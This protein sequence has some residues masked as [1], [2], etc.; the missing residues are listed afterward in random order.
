MDILVIGGTGFIS[1]HLVKKL[2]H[3]NHS[4]TILTRGISQCSLFDSSRMKVIIG[5]RNQESSLRKAIEKTTFDVVFDMVAYEREQSAAAVKVFQGKVGRFIHC[6]TVSVYMVSNEVQCPIT[7]DQDKTPLMEYFARN[8]FGMD[9]GIKKRQCEEILWAA[10]DEKTFPVTM[11]RPTYVSGPGDPARRDYFWIERILDGEPL[12]I[13]GSGD[14]AFQNVYIE[15]VAKAFVSLLDVPRSIGNAYNVAAE[16]IFSLTDYLHALC[17]L[18]NRSPE[19]V[20]VDQNIFDQQSF[21]TSP[22]GDVFTFNSRRTAI[23]SLEKIKRD[24]GYQSTPFKQWMPLTIEWV[25]NKGRQ[26]SAGYERRAEETDFALRWKKL[27]QR[28]RK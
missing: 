2:L 7:E 3:A 5:D 16:E 13:P 28:E 25:V 20:Y 8:P 24:I 4:V 10:H 15:D 27:L 23:F 26:H 18:M 14:H 9:Y 1:G 17:R 6:S 19:Y 12:L 22:N 11:L 21:S